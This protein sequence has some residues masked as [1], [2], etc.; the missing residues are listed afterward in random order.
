MPV[1]LAILWYLWSNKTG[2]NLITF[3]FNIC[4]KLS[5]IRHDNTVPVFIICLSIR[6]FFASYEMSS[7]FRSWIW[8]EGAFLGLLLEF[9]WEVA[10][11]S[12]LIINLYRKILLSPY[13][14]ILIMK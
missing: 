8:Y 10:E 4:G 7:L 11:N 1:L 9:L 2:F 12:E 3:Y 5:K 13:L 14:Q 6:I